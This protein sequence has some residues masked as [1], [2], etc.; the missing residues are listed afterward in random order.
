MGNFIPESPEHIREIS[1]SHSLTNPGSVSVKMMGLCQEESRCVSVCGCAR[2][3]APINEADQV[4]TLLQFIDN[5]QIISPEF[6]LRIHS[7]STSQ[8]LWASG[9][10]LKQEPNS[11]TSMVHVSKDRRSHSVVLSVKHEP[12]HQW[13]MRALWLSFEMDVYSQIFPLSTVG[14]GQAPAK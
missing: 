12:S 2:E 11:L 3:G 13:C 9:N 5:W 4:Q 14:G 7:L 1:V 6:P 8:K 10:I